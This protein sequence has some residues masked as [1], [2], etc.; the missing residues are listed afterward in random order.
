MLVLCLLNG[1]IIY[2]DRTGETYRSPS[3]T[4]V[5][6]YLRTYFFNKFYSPWID[7]S[8]TFNKSCRFINV[9]LDACSIITEGHL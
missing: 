9:K 2:N 1:E 3:L 5:S 6:A 8:L 4:S 7:R